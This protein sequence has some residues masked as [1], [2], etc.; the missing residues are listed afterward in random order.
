LVVGGGVEYEVVEVDRLVAGGAVAG[1]AL[2][3]GLQ[4]QHGFFEC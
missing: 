1:P 4:V 3:E 2:E